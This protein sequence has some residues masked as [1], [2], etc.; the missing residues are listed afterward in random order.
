MGVA[1]P[2]PLTPDGHAVG[3]TMQ[4]LE[5]KFANALSRATAIVVTKI[6]R[7]DHMCPLSYGLFERETACR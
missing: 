4:L 2:L 6:V 7:F 3:E 1:A 5:P